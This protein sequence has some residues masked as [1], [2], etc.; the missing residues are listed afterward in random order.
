[1][2]FKMMVL[3]ISGMTLLIGCASS[4]ITT[5]EPPTSEVLALPDSEPTISPPKNEWDTSSLIEI[6]TQ[7]APDVEELF[8][9]HGGNAYLSLLG[10]D[11]L[12]F[13][14]TLKRR[15]SDY[16]GAFLP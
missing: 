15:D 13:R 4:E 16:S 6:N 11:Q 14:D 5:T 8:V 2:N 1:M 9:L 7:S 3:V 12:E 10:S